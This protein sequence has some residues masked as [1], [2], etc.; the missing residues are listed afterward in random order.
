VFRAVGY[1]AVAY[2]AN[3]GRALPAVA[4][5]VLGLLTSLVVPSQAQSD[6]KAPPKPAAPKPAKPAAAKPSR[7]VEPTP[8]WPDGRVNLGSAP[9]HKGYWELR[10]GFAP[11]VTNVPFQP[12]AKELYTYRQAS[13]KLTRPPYIDCKAAPGPEFL[14]APGFEI[15]DA[16]EMKSVFIIN[17][18]GPH[19]WRVIYTDGRLH[20]KPEDLRPTY[21][22]HS[23]GKWEGDTL[24]V[25]TVGFNEKIWPMGSYPSTEQLHLTERFSRP[26]LGSL[27]YE[28]TIDDPGAY[29]GPW[30]GKTSITET[31]ASSWVT[32]GEMFEYICEDDR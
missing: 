31:T 23:I 1:R 25:D 21:L 24:V 2:R 3:V 16:P 26:T 5:A 4:A 19:S 8:R 14:L 17:I 13:Q 12:W 32:N 22:G 27:V 15:V 11:R 20:P 18:A 30:G 29:T 9:G 28:L 10:P 6:G 7:P